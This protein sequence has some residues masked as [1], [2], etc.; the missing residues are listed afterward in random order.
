MKTRPAR[1]N[2]PMP[3]TKWATL[4]D[5]L[6]DR[7]IT[8][9]ETRAFLATHRFVMDTDTGRVMYTDPGTGHFVKVE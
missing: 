9:A 2:E 4:D 1:V 8:T 7:G 3:G 6:L 5:Y